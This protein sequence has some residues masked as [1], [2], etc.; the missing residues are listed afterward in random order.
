[1]DAMESEGGSRT[2]HQEPGGRN[3]NDDIINNRR[4]K[5]SS[6]YLPKFGCL[7]TETDE[8]G[9]FDVEVDV[10]GEPHAPSHLVVMVNGII[11]SAQDWRFAAKQ[12]LKHYPRDVV[13]HCSECNSS[14]LTFDGVDVMGERLAEE[15]IS[16]IKRHPTVQKISFVG[17]SLGGL[18]ARY[19]IAKLY[20]R[21]I[22]R[23][24]Q[25]NGAS[26]T[27]GLGDKC[28][29]EK[30]RGKIAGLEPVNFITS[31]TPHLGSRGHR[32]VPVFCGFL[33][34]EKVAAQTSWF[35]GRTGKHLFLTDHDDERPPLLLRMVTDHEDL[36]F[37]SA[38]QSFRRHV[39]YANTHFDHIVGWS[40]SSIRHRRELPK[41]KHLS[42]DDRYPHIVHVETSKAATSEQDVS[43]ENKVAGFERIDMEDEMLRSLTKLSWERVDVNFGGSKQRFMAHSTI[44][45]KSY[46]INSDGADVIQHMIDN[47]LL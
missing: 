27:D 24:S 45:V 10:E 47:F 4:K 40:S 36:K 37:M 26:Q 11:G 34:L 20:G 17:H 2:A 23:V 12:F 3:N 41:N 30:F 8:D 28:H 18:V 44:Q 19:A 35:L 16:V 6:S 29:E 22:S 39:A 43:L 38:L 14:M 15:V 21:D 32:Q 7:R 42:R 31:A 33:K 5:R 1:M 9:S 46:R 13:V 25:G